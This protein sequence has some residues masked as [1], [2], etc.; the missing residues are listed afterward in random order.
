[1]GPWRS[2]GTGKW[3]G[4][5]ASDRFPIYTR[6][7]AG[8]VYPEV[9]RPLSFSIAQQGGEVAMRNAILASGV[10]RPKELAD[11]PLSTAIGSG[12]FGGYAYLNLSIQRLGAARIPGGS[13]S[14]ADNSFLGAGD[15]PPHVP[16]PNE[17]NRRAGF[18]G[19]RY[20]WKMS[21]TTELPQLAADQHTVDE[22]L[23]SLPDP[24]TAADHELRGST[25]D[26]TEL[27]MPMFET[28]LKVSFGAGALMSALTQTCEQQL[29]DAEI[30]VRLVSGLGDVDSAAPSTAL[31]SLGR[32][33]AGSPELTAEFDAGVPGLWQRVQGL[34]PAIVGSFVADFVTFIADFGSRGPNEWDTA[35]DTWETDPDM[36]LVFVDRMRL[37][38]PSHAPTAQRDR[39]A[40]ERNALEAEV[41]HRLKRPIRPVFRRLLRS[42]RLYMQSRERTKTTVVRAIHGARLQAQELDR[43]LIERSGG[44]RGDLWFMIDEELDAY[45]ADP[46]SFADTIAERRAMHAELARRIPPFYFEGEQPPLEEWELRS[47]QLPPVTVG[48][49]L[50]GMAGC[51]GVATGRARV[52]TD[53][54]DPRGL[55]PGDVLIAPLTDPSWTP[56]FVPAEAVV[57]DVGAVMS[58]AIIVS[59]ELGIPCAVS[60]TDA[61]RRIPDGALIEVDGGT[62]A[63]RILELPA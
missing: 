48:E 1:M 40:A 2:I 8:E 61:T 26:I 32:Q 41:L 52:V 11:I 49:V 57:V 18:A 35:F 33:V 59:R 39:L 54:T 27:F 17:K 37:T 63:V 20:V 47:H 10:I 62:G 23:A 7:N 42:T 43:R 15:P 36:A 19:L 4:T 3:V 14:D 46:S 16:L 56:L 9:Y 21:G 58:H 30:A 44:E 22:F 5:D 29:G 60:V 28:H 12:V 50:Q 25:T 53:P 51:A 13:W 45:V 55:E 31:W 6:G 38:D 24:A 34:D